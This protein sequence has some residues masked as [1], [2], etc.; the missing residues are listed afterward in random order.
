M[1]L[2]ASTTLHKALVLQ[3]VLRRQCFDDASLEC[4]CSELVGGILRVTFTTGF[5]LESH[6]VRVPAR[7]LRAAET[8]RSVPHWPAGQ[9]TVQC[10][11]HVPRLPVR[12][13]P[14]PL[15]RTTAACR[16]ATP[17]GR[18]LAD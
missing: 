12:V 8:P 1:I 18:K 17:P 7:P 4:R 13:P 15:P 14:G 11:I 10:Q 5:G 2:Y 9:H 3:S 16:C 6:F